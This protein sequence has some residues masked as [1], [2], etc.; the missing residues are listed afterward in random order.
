MRIFPKENVYG[1]FTVPSD[2]SI[3]ERAIILGSLAAGKTYI[4][5]P[6]AND[7][8]S[9]LAT[10]MKKLGA[11]IRVKN[12]IMEIRCAKKIRSEQR[13][14]CGDSAAVMRFLCGVAAGSGVRAIL[15]GSKSLCQMPMR[16]VKEPLEKMGATVALTRYSVPPVLVEGAKVRPVE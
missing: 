5:N 6:I 15:T 16:Q 1:E 14:D 2:K 12:G 11:K 8:T 3:T 4:V 9:S 7:E 13:L 10:C